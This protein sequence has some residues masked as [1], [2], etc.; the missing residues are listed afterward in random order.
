MHTDR[1]GVSEL[2]GWHTA[3]LPY[4]RGSTSRG[5]LSVFM[6]QLR[7]CG[8]PACEISGARFR[9]CECG[10]RDRYYVLHT[11]AVLHPCI[12]T[13][14][15]R[16]YMLEAAS[17]QRAGQYD[18]RRLVG[19][20]AVDDDLSVGAVD[21]D[22]VFAAGHI[23]QHGSRNALWLQYARAVGVYTD[24]DGCHARFDQ[25]VQLIG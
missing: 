24:D 3:C 23:I 18:G 5:A 12:D 17:H 21:L 2:G 14:M 20:G 10:G 19:T 6:C 1:C 4:L 8:A 22:C 9:R 16:T 11:I 13:A 7:G 15:Q 25:R